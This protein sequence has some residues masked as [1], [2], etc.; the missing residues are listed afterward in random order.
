MVNQL[1]FAL[2]NAYIDLVQ[3]SHDAA[4]D[5]QF[6]AGGNFITVKRGDRA[7]FYYKPSVKDPLHQTKTVYVGPADNLEIARRVK[8]FQ[9]IKAAYRDRSAVVR[10]LLAAGVP[11]IPDPMTLNVIDALSKAGLF[12]LRGVLVGTAAFNTYAGLLGVR[13]PG[14]YLRTMD[15]DFAQF[16]SISVLVGDS[17]PPL[18]E[19]LE[20]LDASFRPIQPLGR[21]DPPASY[22]NSKGY[23]VEFLTPNRGADDHQGHTSTMPALAQG[24]ATPLRYLDFLI[25]QPVQAVILHAGGIPVTVPAPERFA[26]HKLI[27]S[28]LRKADLDGRGKAQ[29]DAMQ[30]GHLIESLA[31]RERHVDLGEIWVEAWERGPKWQQALAIGRSRLDVAKALTL[32]IS[33]Q[34]FSDAAGMNFEQVWKRNPQGTQPAARL[35]P[36]D[37]VEFP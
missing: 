12:R 14:A 18:M 24:G 21:S 13:I 5:A 26:I 17:T 16:H 31:G 15:A 37:G 9:L 28:S 34:K 29:K 19:I 25:Y 22:I 30:A 33:V 32:K 1:P 11:T 7:Y 10:S 27:V 4:F 6:G 2:H 3:T 20:P 36:N 8:N 23:K 35:E